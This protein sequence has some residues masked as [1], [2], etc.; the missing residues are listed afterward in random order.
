[1]NIK[2]KAVMM[3]A[4]AGVVLQGAIVVVNVAASLMMNPAMTGGKPNEGLAAIVGLM[5]V[6][7]CLCAL[8]LDSG[9][10][11]L[12]AFMHSREAALTVG[13]AALG[14]GVSGLVTRVITSLCAMCV[15]LAVL[16]LMAV[17]VGNA[18]GDPSMGA[19]TGMFGAMGGVVGGLIGVCLGAIV[20]VILG[21]LG[22]AIA[23]V[24]VRNQSTAV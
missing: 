18:T 16:P 14:G 12:Y 3:A 17:R 22:G 20:G 4:G 11:T 9:V 6:V 5:T 23:G 2:P 21:A 10:G 13:D 7:L 19:L 8:M 24:V 15:N 1:M